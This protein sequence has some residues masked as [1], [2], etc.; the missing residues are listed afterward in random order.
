MSAPSRRAAKPAKV[1]SLYGVTDKHREQAEAEEAEFGRSVFRRDYGRLLHSP[2]FRRLQGKTQ[3]F[4]GAESDF[5]RNRLTHSLEVAQIAKG[6][7]QQL[8]TREVEFQDVSTSID[9]D[10]VEFAGLAHDLGHPP[11]GHNG[12]KAL[13]DCM[14]Q[15]GG[16]EGNAQTL[17]I[18]SRIEKK[19]VNVSIAGV[20]TA[21]GFSAKGED[22]RLGLNLSYRSLAAILKYD[23]EIPVSRTDGSPLVKGYYAS[24]K[25][26]V[27]RIKRAVGAQATGNAFKTIE[28]QIMDL[29]DDIAYSTYDLE[30]AMKGGF[31]HPLELVA[32]VA[33]DDKLSDDL[34]K[35]VSEDIKPT[36]VSKG[37]ILQEML[38]LIPAR[39]KR[40]D[41][42]GVPEYLDSVQVASNGYFRSNLTSKLVGSF[43]R[44][45]SIVRPNDTE[46]KFAQLKVP[47][48]TLLRIAILKH[49]NYLLMIMSPRLKVV[50]YRGYE[51][52][53]A[54]FEVL[55]SD[56]GHLLLPQD[57]REMYRRAGADVDKKRLICDFIAGMTDRYAVQFF[58]ALK[59]DGQSIF[60]PI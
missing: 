11:F 38:N 36:Q 41:N 22:A 8:N 45:V 25:H 37:E 28:C 32:K 2:S 31:T 14:K 10:L 60:R 19:V 50:E 53:Q 27:E 13:D 54:I 3:L 29:A 1:A 9:L 30:D 42:R 58:N 51:I 35:K 43:I 57:Y 5:F 18:L 7:A 24:E 47:H 17:R 20:D 46:L 52:V 48:V 39:T 26:L 44:D 16:F 33:S 12:E 4:P 59:G 23:R 56:E 49:L 6:I 40:N 21:C 34:A 55:D 15:Y